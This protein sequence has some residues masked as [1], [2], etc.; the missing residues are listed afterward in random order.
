M[1]NLL[2]GSN[3]WPPTV[4]TITDYFYL[5]YILREEF[6]WSIGIIDEIIRVLERDQV[7]EKQ[8]I[9]EVSISFIESRLSSLTSSIDTISKETSQF[10]VSNYVYDPLQQTSATLTQIEE[11]KTE[12]VSLGIQKEI[13][14]SILNSLKDN[15]I[16]LLPLNVG[17][18]DASLNATIAE[19]NKVLLERE[20]LLVSA[21]EQ[22]PLVERLTVQ[23][24]DKKQIIIDGLSKYVSNIDLSLNSY[25]NLENEAQRM[26]SAI[27]AK[28]TKLTELTLNSTLLQ[29]LYV[30]LL[31]R[32]EE[33]SLAYVSAL[34]TLKVL[35]PALG[36][37]NPID[38][39]P[40]R[41]YSIALAL[42]LNLTLGILLLL[43]VLD[44]KIN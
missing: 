23:L 42:G 38:P 6:E 4:H 20:A 26:V 19:Y 44:T 39:I 1:I 29:E 3:R 2:R 10:R 35:S 16:K 30:F 17:I 5:W 24:K 27:P 28:E 14:L 31:Q 15:S 22:S 36:G 32:K 34:P 33:A 18:E 37:P 11:S 41:V 9:S 8:K 21:T 43:R 25:R 7:Y 40:L 12:I 13:A